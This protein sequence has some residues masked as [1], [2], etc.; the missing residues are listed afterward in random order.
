MTYAQYGTIAAADYNGLVGTSP[1][2]TANQVNTIW[3]VGNGKSGYGQTPL[4]Q[5]SQNG[6]ISASAW[7][8]LYTTIT[9]IASLQGTAIT[10]LTN[11]VA[12]NSITYNSSLATNISNIYAGRGNLASGSLGTSSTTTTTNSSTWSSGITFTHTVTFGSGDQA[13]YFFNAG[14]QIAISFSHPTGTGINALFSTLASAC[15][16][17]VI[18]SP[19]TGTV[20]IGGVSYNGVTKVGGSGTTTPS[21]PNLG[22]YGLTTTSQ[23]VFSQL[24]TG[25]PTGYDSSTISVALSTNNATGSNG[26]NGSVI[27]IVTSWTEVP[28][29]LVMSANTTTYVTIKPPATGYLPA[30]SWG[31]ITV[32]AGT[33]AGS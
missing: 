5:V 31:T 19:N 17:I 27:T 29:G 13:R 20:S 10:A 22:Y 21:L 24:A 14:G 2:S 12:G 28:T 30:A 9:N 4:A 6:S 16:T 18:S 7:A 15:G 11:P 23:T 32:S 8:S 25:N 1:S 3:A 33:I 26:D